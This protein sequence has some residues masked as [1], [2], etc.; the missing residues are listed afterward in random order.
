MSSFGNWI[1]FEDLAFLFSK[2]L[3]SILWLIHILQ[4]FKTNIYGINHFL[5]KL[6]YSL[7]DLVGALI[8]Q[9]SLISCTFTLV[10]LSKRI[11]SIHNLHWPIRRLIESH[12][13]HRDQWE[14]SIHRQSC[15][16]SWTRQCQMPELLTMDTCNV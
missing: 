2:C 8:E 10:L 16:Q 5:S 13:T 3:G 14:S 6:E 9:K 12:M 7:L 11:D 1:E 15:N 4:E